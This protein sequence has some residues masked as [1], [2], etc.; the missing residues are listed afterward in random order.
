MQMSEEYFVGIR[1]GIILDQHRQ[2]VPVW[3]YTRDRMTLG[4][5]HMIVLES[6]A[7]MIVSL[8]TFKKRQ[9]YDAPHSFS[10]RLTHLFTSR[11][12][13][14]KIENI[15]NTTFHYNNNKK[16]L[17]KMS[18][19]FFFI[20]LSYVQCCTIHFLYCMVGTAELPTLTIF[21]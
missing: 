10:R 12:P 21:A 8:I 6:W 2:Q 3:Q 5:D 20:G 1:T 13:Q 18:L 14:D 15:S 16:F 11:L 4:D 17:I 9:A 19:I 7:S